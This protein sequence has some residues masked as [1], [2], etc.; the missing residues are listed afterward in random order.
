M[1]TQILRRVFTTGMVSLAALTLTLATVQASDTGRTQA[2]PTVSIAPQDVRLVAASTPKRHIAMRYAKAQEGD[3][4][5]YGGTG[6]SSWD[7]SGLVM[8]AYKK[9]GKSLP[10]TTGSMYS[11]STMT[12]VSKYNV[13]WGDPVFFGTGHVELFAHWGNKAKT[14]G[15]TFGAHRSG[16][17]VSYRKFS[18][19]SSYHPTRF[20]HVKGTG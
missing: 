12:T 16:T 18:M 17:R 9:A 15:Y 3:P 8:V 5:R 11:S 13:R 6:P 19:G 4:Y 2:A 10:R 14:W 20:R 1:M 7:C